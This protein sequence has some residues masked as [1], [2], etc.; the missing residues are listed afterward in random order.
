MKRTI[1]CAVMLAVSLG[2]WL[3]GAA[4]GQ[5]VQVSD[6]DQQF[7]RH[8]ASDGLAEVQMGNL[9]T[10]RATNPAVQRFGQQMVTDHTKA[11][12]EL[13][14]LAQS[15]NISIPKEADKQHQKTAEMLTKKHGANFDREYMRDMVKDHEKAVQLFSTVAKE[16]QDADIKAFANQTLPTLQEHLQMAH[17]LTQQHGRTSQAR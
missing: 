2:W 4:V 7:L 12:Q 6:K 10:E 15:K 17:Q 5:A 14:A 8:A 9:A 1:I 16:A 13:T 3:T 11:N